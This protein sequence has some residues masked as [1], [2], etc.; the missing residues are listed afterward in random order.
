[1]NELSPL[2]SA[3]P[4]EKCLNILWARGHE[5]H[6]EKFGLEP[7]RA[8]LKAL[9]N[10]ERHYSTAIVAG[11]NGKGSTSAMLAAMLEHAGYR[12]GLYSSPHLVRVNERVRINGCEISDQDFAA[13]FTQVHRAIESLIAAGVLAHRPSFFEYLTA[14]AFQH[15]ARAAVDFAV[16]EVGMGG[17]LDATNVTDASVAVITNVDLDHQEFLG[18]THVAIAGEKAGVIK[19]GRVVVSGCEHPDVVEVIRRK[20]REVGVQLIETGGLRGASNIFHLDGRYGFDLEIDGCSLPGV[21]LKMPGRFQVKNA[22]AAATAATVLR[23]EGFRLSP[24]SIREGLR[25]AVWPGRMETIRQR[26]LIMLDGAHNPAAASEVAE[27]YHRHLDG[28][29]LQLV[30]ATMRDKAIGEIS[31]ILFPLA[32]TVFL[33][34]PDLDRAATPEAIMA[35]VKVRPGEIVVEPDPARALEQA[36]Y[37]SLPEDIVLVAGSLFLVGAIKKAISEGRLDPANLAPPEVL[38]ERY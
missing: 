2:H 25:A 28:R 29:R 7:I 30:Y 36:V 34:R 32:H 19:P 8:I 9:G 14:T 4:Y 22:I 31:S 20:S 26:P 13:A 37:S 10:P 35:A 27:F 17:R 15:F 24:E 33:A 5:L 3:I 11:T 38:S 21:T 23:R 16:L 18:D 6:G 12:T 1:M